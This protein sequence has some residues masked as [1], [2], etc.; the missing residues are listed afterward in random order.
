[1]PVANGA[2]IAISFRELDIKGVR[3]ALEGLNFSE[4]IASRQEWANENQDRP[5][6]RIASCDIRF[7]FFIRH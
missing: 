7:D 4:N 6:K 5:K 1:M 3:H 2:P